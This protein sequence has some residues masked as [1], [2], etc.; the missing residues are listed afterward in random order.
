MRVGTPV[1]GPRNNGRKELARVVRTALAVL[2]RKEEGARASLFGIGL[3]LAAVA[4]FSTNGALGKWVIATVPVG[5]F[6]FLRALM[7]LL[8]VA[9]YYWRNGLAPIRNAPRKGLQLV[10]IVLSAVEIA[11]FYWTLSYL[12]LAVSSVLQF[13]LK[14]GFENSLIGIPFGSFRQ[15]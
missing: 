12:P 7:A 4:V 15:G 14:V 13:S 10:R 3:M 6:L 1:G 5:E 2:S 8:L 9:P 11:I